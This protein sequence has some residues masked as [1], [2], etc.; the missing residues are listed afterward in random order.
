M[1]GVKFVKVSEGKKFVLTEDGMAI[2]RIRAKYEV[3]YERKFVYEK[4][5]PQSW[6]DRGY[7][8]EVDDGEK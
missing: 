1:A 3:T 2:P 4:T 6:V 7:V 5:V 8:V